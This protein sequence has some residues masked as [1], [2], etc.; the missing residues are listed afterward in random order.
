MFVFSNGWKRD[1]QHICLDQV[2]SPFLA[3]FD[4][5]ASKRQACE[6][7]YLDD[8]IVFFVIGP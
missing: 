7:E 1:V 3:R 4:L 5:Y 8:Q 2:G 6:G